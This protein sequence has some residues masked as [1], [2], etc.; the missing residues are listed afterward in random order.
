MSSTTTNPWQHSESVPWQNSPAA[1]VMR[2]RLYHVGASESGVVSSIVKYAPD[3]VF[4]PHQHPQG[5]EILVLDGVFSDEHGDY[6]AGTHV[7]NPDGSSHSPFSTAGCTLWVKLRQYAGDGRLQHRLDGNKLKWQPLALGS[8]QKSL[9]QQEGFPERVRL[10]KL[11]A[12]SEMTLEGKAELLLL[13]GELRD[14]H[15]EHRNGA[16]LRLEWQQHNVIKAQRQSEFY[17]CQ[18]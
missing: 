14:Q 8:W 7:L 13:S 4:A 6:P 17:L 1:G 18:Y 2:K 9:Y 10:I 3:S 12:G 16:Y 11:A 15:G 5:E